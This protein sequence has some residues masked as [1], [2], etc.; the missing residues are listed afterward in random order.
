MPPS[1]PQM[2]SVVPSAARRF[3]R[4]FRV[5][6]TYME[7]S[8]PTAIPRGPLN[9][10]RPLRSWNGPPSPLMVGDGLGVAEAVVLGDGVGVAVGRT[11]PNGVDVWVLVDVAEAVHVGDGPGVLVIVEVADAVHVA[12]EVGVAVG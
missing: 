12:V 6:A 3:T 10:L 4:L 1:A 9:W 5:S 7:P 11:Q 2:E 8:A